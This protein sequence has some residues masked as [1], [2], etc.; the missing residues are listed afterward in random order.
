ME[1]CR[2]RTERNFCKVNYFKNDD[3]MEIYRRCYEEC[4]GIDDDV[5]RFLVCPHCGTRYPVNKSYLG[6]YCDDNKR[7]LL[8]P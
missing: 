8:C 1:E 4:G 3:G 2:H 5:N 7:N 6:C